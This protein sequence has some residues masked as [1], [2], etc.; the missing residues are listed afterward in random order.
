MAKKGSVYL[1]GDGNLKSNPIHGEDL[2]E[3]CVD[4]VNNADSEIKVGGPETLS[5]NEISM[6]AFEVLGKKPKIVHIPDWIR[7]LTLRL[8]RI[9]SGSK[10]YGPIEFFLTVMSM[11]MVAPEYGKHRLINFFKELK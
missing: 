8:V 10:T 1:F 11:E 6:L 2:A 4:T 7:K 3:V 9:F 5:Q